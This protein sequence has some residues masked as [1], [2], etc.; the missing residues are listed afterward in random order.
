M[1]KK[2]IKQI[3][4]RLVNAL[5]KQNIKTEKVVLFGSYA[6]GN[7]HKDSDLDLLI[8]SSDFRGQNLLE[9]AKILARAHWEVP[10][11]PM[12]IVGVTPDEWEKA[13]SLIIDYA[14]NGKLVYA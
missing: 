4:L 7:S 11:Y 8:I 3:V 6:E 1:G 2:T 9:R 5:H 12:D 10:D 14:K 13:D